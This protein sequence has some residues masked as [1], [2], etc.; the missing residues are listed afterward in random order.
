M[1]KIYFVRHAKPDFSVHEDLIRPL[2]E[3]GLK[4][5]KNVTE[6]LKD[7]EITKVYASPYKRAI[8]TVRGL[9][10]KLNLDIIIKND[11]RER[12]VSE[13][14]IED[15]N[16]FS[17]GQWEDF[18]YKLPKGE[19]LKE[20]QERNVQALQEI[21]KESC[22]NNIVIGTH[23][24]ALS[25]IIN[26]HNKS[27]GYDEFNR[28]KNIMPWIVVMEFQGQNLVNIEEMSLNK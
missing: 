25:T 2:T 3:E 5:S 10:D 23:G 11:L 9:A 17:K 15:F 20:V 24:T 12:A 26:H 14:W 4:D 19:C 22:G 7:K 28:I 27:F 6:F 1:T 8:D 18:N 13:E 16:A 21:L